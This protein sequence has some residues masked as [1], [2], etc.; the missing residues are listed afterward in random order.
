[1]MR[2]HAYKVRL[3]GVSLEMAKLRIAIEN[4]HL[5]EAFSLLIGIEAILKGKN[6]KRHQPAKKDLA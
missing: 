5:D 1:M 4:R 6:W 3:D 2:E